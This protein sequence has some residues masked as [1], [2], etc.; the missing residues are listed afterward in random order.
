MNVDDC[1]CSMKSRS[2]RFAEASYASR[3]EKSYSDSD[4]RSVKFDIR[5]CKNLFAR[6]HARCASWSYWRR[7]GVG[8]TGM[9]KTMTSLA[10]SSQLQSSIWICPVWS[11]PTLC[12]ASNCRSLFATSEFLSLFFFSVSRISTRSATTDWL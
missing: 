2:R 8:Q 1:N 12:Y 6:C 5:Y 7:V 4:L 9:W 10:L 3:D 11:S